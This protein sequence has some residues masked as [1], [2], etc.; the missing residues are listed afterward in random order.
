MITLRLLVPISDQFTFRDHIRNSMDDIALSCMLKSSYQCPP[1]DTRFFT[2]HLYT[3]KDR[4]NAIIVF[5]ALSAKFLERYWRAMKSL[6]SFV[7]AMKLF[8]KGIDILRRNE[9]FL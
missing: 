3:I 7:E 5:F 1:V 6:C 8:L 2:G 4:H 9:E